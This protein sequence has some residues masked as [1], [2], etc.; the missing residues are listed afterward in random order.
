MLLDLP[1]EIVYKIFRH[2]DDSTLRNLRKITH[3]KSY[4]HEIDKI[5]NNKLCIERDYR[6]YNINHFIRDCFIEQIIEDHNSILM[7]R[8]TWRE[9]KVQAHEFVMIYT[10]MVERS[11]KK[12]NYQISIDTLLFTYKKVLDERIV[13]DNNSYEKIKHYYGNKFMDIALNMDLFNE[14]QLHRLLLD[15]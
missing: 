1:V 7:Q 11:I 9:L 13:L 4:F 8:E 15:T 12:L 2:A 3:L 10:G 14:I 5:L 6:N